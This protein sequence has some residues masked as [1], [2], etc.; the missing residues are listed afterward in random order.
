M[1]KP[2]WVS[3]S[4]DDHALVMNHMRRAL[5][6]AKQLGSSSIALTIRADED[7]SPAVQRRRAADRLKAAADLCAE[8]GAVI[9][10]EPLI[11]LPGMLLRTFA[12]GVELVRGAGHPGLKLLYDTGHLTA[13]GDPLLPS[14]IEAFDDICTIQIVDMP[15]RVEP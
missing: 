9:A 2:L 14:F 4:A 3:D 11:L 13:M 6:V 8:Q 15:G 1:L 5:G 10:L 7:T 12:E